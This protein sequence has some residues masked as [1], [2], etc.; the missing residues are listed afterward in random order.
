MSLGERAALEGVLASLKPA[1]AVEIGTAEGGSL[2]RISEHSQEVHSF[3]LVAPDPE[4]AAIEHASFHSGDSHALLPAFLAELDDAG[5]NVDFVLV[6]GDHSAEGVRRDAEDLLASTAI[7]QTVIL[8][9]DTANPHVR[10]GID[11]VDFDAHAKIV[12]VEPDFVAG[13]VFSH[14]DLEGEIWGGLGI[15]I[16]N[17]A[18]PRSPQR[19]AMQQRIVPTA[20]LLR[21]ARDRRLSSPLQRLRNT[22]GA[23]LSR[24]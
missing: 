2:R 3:D 11:A 6:D 4:I 21:E 14:P 13:S 5:R 7:G 22:V 10:S 12:H 20:T 9:H 16:A 23:R 19:S 17:A 24:R 8:F 15:V 1:L 18:E